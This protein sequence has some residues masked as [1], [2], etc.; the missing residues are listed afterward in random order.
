MEREVVEGC[1]EDDLLI[2]RLMIDG[3]G[4]FGE[5]WR[6]SFDGGFGGGEDWEVRWWKEKVGLVV[7]EA[8]CR[9]SSQVGTDH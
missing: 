7:A 6:E 2:W 8:I 5:A 4:S 1:F 9:A 3:D